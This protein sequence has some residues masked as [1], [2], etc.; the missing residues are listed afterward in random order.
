MTNDVGI[1]IYKGKLTNSLVVPFCLKV[2]SI[3]PDVKD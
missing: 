1:V 2:G 3:P